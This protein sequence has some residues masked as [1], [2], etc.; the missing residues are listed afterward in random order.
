MFVTADSKTQNRS[1]AP[2]V[3]PGFLPVEVGRLLV[4]LLVDVLPFG[5][6]L[7]DTAGMVRG[8]TPYLF[9]NPDYTAPG[10]QNTLRMYLRIAPSRLPN[11]VAILL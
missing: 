7:R 9:A 5:G 3:I 6:C 1:N 4:T 10:T 11:I 8:G 2:R